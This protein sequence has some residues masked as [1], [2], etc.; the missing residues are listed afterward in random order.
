MKQHPIL[1]F[2]V[3]LMISA[4]FWGCLNNDIC[5]PDLPVECEFY[6]Q[7]LYAPLNILVTIDDDNPYVPIEIYVGDVEDG[8]LY[9]TDTLVDD[10]RY[11]VDIDARYSA[12]AT[13]QNLGRTIIAVDGDRVKSKSSDNC[14]ITCWEAKS[15]TINLRLKK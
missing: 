9:L 8:N 6:D 12:T 10:A 7:P 5:D 3:A 15:G 11:E 2:L 4:N 13:Y 1:I 14:G